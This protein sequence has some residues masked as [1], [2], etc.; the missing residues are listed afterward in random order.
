[1]SEFKHT[2]GPWVIRVIDLHEGGSGFEIVGA[3]GDIVCDNQTYYPHAIDKKNARLI[4]AAPEL[5][6]AL[7]RLMPSAEDNTAGYGGEPDEDED[8]L[9]ARAAIAKATGGQE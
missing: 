6:E 2:P 4:A 7:V 3:N 8:I 5:L 1:M 9:F